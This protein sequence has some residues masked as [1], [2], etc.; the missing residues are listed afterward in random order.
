MNSEEYSNLSQLE[1]EHWFYRGKRAIVRFWI[2]RY[3]KLTEHS[4]L[5]DCGAGTGIWALEMSRDCKVLAVDDYEESIAIARQNLGAARVIKA[6]CDQL[7]LEDGTVHCVTA[8]DVI[9]HIEDDVAAIREISRVIAPE[10]LLVVTVPALMTLWSDWDVSLHHFR[11]YSRPELKL[12]L[13]KNGFEVIEIR[14]VNTLVFPVVWLARRLRKW[15]HNTQDEKRSEDQIPPKWLNKLLL[16]WFIFEGTNR[17]LS[18]PFGVGLVA[19][20]R[21]AKRLI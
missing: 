1:T 20:C 14:Y 21:P 5:V 4:L 10:G 16:K 3:L 6:P 9:E 8:L 17:W 7:P 19:I 18:L 15:R 13:S 2:E 11:R 12:L